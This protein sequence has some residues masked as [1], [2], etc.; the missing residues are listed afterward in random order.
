MG[1]FNINAIRQGIPSYAPG[2]TQQL[3]QMQQRRQMPQG[4]F[5]RPQRPAGVQRPQMSMQRPQMGMQGPQ[6]GQR[7]PPQQGIKMGGGWNPGD[8]AIAGGGRVTGQQWASAPQWARK[9]AKGEGKP[10]TKGETTAS[11]LR[12]RV[13][14]HD[15]Y[16]NPIYAQPQG[17]ATSQRQWE[18][19][20]W[21]NALRGSGPQNYSAYQ[22]TQQPKRRKNRAAVYD[23]TG[24][25]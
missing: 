5:Q 19:S 10:P 12:G 23:Y 20:N 14:D 24:G 18:Q 22:K 8:R 15:S 7:P 2:K 25:A 17:G 13:V 4:G 3:G 16:G 11:A 21:K 6:M 1:N 9:W